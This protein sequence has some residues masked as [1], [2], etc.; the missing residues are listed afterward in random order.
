MSLRS[1]RVG[2]YC[3]VRRRAVTGCNAAWHRANTMVHM[4]NWANGLGNKPEG[5]QSY[6]KL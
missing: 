1:S 5:D 4:A 6:F 2:R 3:A